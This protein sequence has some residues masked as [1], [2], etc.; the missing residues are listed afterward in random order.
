ML[1]VIAAASLIS[2]AQGQPATFEVASIRADKTTARASM[3]P[4]PGGLRFIA[5]NMPLL[6]LIGE[7]YHVANGQ[8]S[9]L[10]DELSSS[11]YDIEAKSEHPVSRDQMMRMLQALLE[12]RF[13]LV[14]RHETK[15]MKAHVLVVAKGGA[16]LDENHDG[17]ELAI[18]KISGNKTSYHNMPMSLFAN[19]LSGAV[20]DSVMDR[21]GLNGSYDFTLDYYRGPGGVG[22]LEGREPAPDPNGPS[23]Y[24]A[25]RQQLGLSL[26][27]RN[28]PVELLIIDHVEKLSEN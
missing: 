25:L 9:G 20:D 11:R 2:F 13:K 22:V 14:I 3:G 18:R 21:T 6:W 10:P 1:R 15:E 17:E 19:V 12:D 8:I 24:T 28:V 26:E 5:R 7:A 16:K 27:S 4:T 23:L